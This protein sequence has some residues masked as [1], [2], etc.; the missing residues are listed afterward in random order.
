M[1][2]T[3]VL[4]GKNNPKNRCFTREGEWLIIGQD[5]DRMNGTLPEDHHFFVGVNSH[6]PSRYGW[7]TLIKDEIDP[8]DLAKK[9]D[10]VPSAKL[11]EDCEL[12]LKAVS[13]QQEGTPMACTFSTVGV[14]QKTR[15]LRVHKVIFHKVRK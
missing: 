1:K 9:Y 7:V 8:E 5:N 2:F 13:S 10:P 3:K 12:L 15:V 11:I 6:K 4:T 14:M